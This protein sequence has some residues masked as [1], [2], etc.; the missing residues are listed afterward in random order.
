MITAILTALVILGLVGLVCAIVLVIASHFFAVVEDP[1]VEEASAILPGI[2]CGGCGY[3]GC[4]EYAK[5]VVLSGVPPDLCKPG[6][7]DTAH[8]LAAMVGASVSVSERKVA[9]V[10]CQGDDKVASRSSSYNGPADCLAADLAAGGGKT[11]R[12]G[13]LGLGNCSRACPVNA[14]EITP[15]CLAAVHPELCIGCGKCVATCP[16]KLIKLI[17]ESRTIHVLC[18][19]RDKGPVVKKACSVGCIACTLCTK[20]VSNQGI[21]MNGALA[22]VDYGVPLTNEAVIAKCPTHAIVKRSGMKEGV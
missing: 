21:H 4:S 15:A 2:N 13:C 8:K 5:A 17:P 7:P 12:Y 11:C 14:I 16:R 9:I 10:L 20:L 18:S 1:R 22:V 19:S 3:A 6:G